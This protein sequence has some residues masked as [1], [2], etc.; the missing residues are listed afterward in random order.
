MR[1]IN[2]IPLRFGILRH[3]E[4]RGNVRMRRLSGKRNLYG[5]KRLYLYLRQRIL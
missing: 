3:G 4:R 1:R 5:R 2:N